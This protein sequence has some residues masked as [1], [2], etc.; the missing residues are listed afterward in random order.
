VFR[1][2]RQVSSTVSPSSPNYFPVQLL[3]NGAEFSLN[4]QPTRAFSA[5]ATYAYLDA[6]Y[7]NQSRG[8]LESDY[9]GYVPDGVTLYA[10]ST[11]SVNPESTLRGNWRLNGIPLS[12]VNTYVSYQFPNGLGVRANAWLTS[13][14]K[15]SRT[16]SV[17]SEYNVGVGVFYANKHWRAALDFLNVTNQRDWGHGAGVGGDTTQFLLQS[18]PFGVQGKLAYKF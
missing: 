4:Y 3:Y 2:T 15:A 17:P 13:D 12:T 7:V 8:S 5:G 14:W 6:A 18:L 16:V 1:Q 11:G 9:N 10:N